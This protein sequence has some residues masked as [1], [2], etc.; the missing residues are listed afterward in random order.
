VLADRHH[1]L[2]IVQ[3]CSPPR[4]NGLTL[5]SLGEA[6]LPSDVP[7]LLDLPGELSCEEEE[8]VKRLRETLPL[9]I[10]RTPEQLV[11]ELSSLLHQPLSA[12]P[13]AQ[14][15]AVEKRHDPATVLAGKDV[16]IVD[17]D[18]RNIFAMTSLLERFDMHV[19][20]SETGEEAI[21]IL[22]SEAGIDIVLMDIMMPKLDGYETTRA[23]RQKQAFRDLPIIALTAKA[24][25]GDR[26]KCL[27]AGASDYVA[28]PVRGDYLVEVLAR[29]LR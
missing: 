23:I 20:S 2:L 27:E 24:M 8:I 26:E 22:E 13:K 17:D 6:E 25:V 12:L 14:R 7:I 19:R 1:D 11:D 9:R 15:E 28:K 21:E 18:I 5:H 4:P 29:W 3:P 10:A 16:L